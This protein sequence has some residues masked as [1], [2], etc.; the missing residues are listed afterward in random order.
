ME[1]EASACDDESIMSISSDEGKT[2][3]KVARKRLGRVRVRK[4]I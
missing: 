3:A 4:K 1:D 2:K